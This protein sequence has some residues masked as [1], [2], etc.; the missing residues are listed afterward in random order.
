MVSC[1]TRE[2]GKNRTNRIKNTIVGCGYT[3]AE[4]G[5]IF[6]IYTHAHTHKPTA[7]GCGFASAARR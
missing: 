5:Y 6:I 7:A 4:S 3:A 1:N 2:N